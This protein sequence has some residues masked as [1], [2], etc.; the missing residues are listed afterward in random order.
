M[1]Y[2][3]VLPSAESLGVYYFW[4]FMFVATTPIEGATVE[5]NTLQFDRTSERYVF[6][7]RLPSKYL[8]VV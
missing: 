6:V 8:S 7:C 2:R 5:R 1:L 4:F 3:R